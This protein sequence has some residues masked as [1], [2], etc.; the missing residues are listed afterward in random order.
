M[1]RVIVMSILGISLML[2]TSSSASFRP[3]KLVED[4]D[5]RLDAAKEE[6]S[7]VGDVVEK[8][9]DELLKMIDEEVEDGLFRLDELNEKF[10]N[11]VEDLRQELGEVLSSEQLQKIGGLLDNLNSELIASISEGII[12]SLGK[13]LHVSSEQLEKL[14]PILGDELMTRGRL[15]A[16]YL[17][18]GGPTA[19]ASFAAENEE[20][21]ES[22]NATLQE[23][24]SPEQMEEL[25]KW[26]QEFDR[27]IEG[28]FSQVE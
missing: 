2:S 7:K 15:L 16:K 18:L 6:I 1:K 22:M 5:Q 28:L 13:R 20:L 25:G 23:I 26:Q 19:L 17:T 10:G 4:I 3:K 27:K 12:D 14:S 24:L 9:G 8:R 21:R 11:K